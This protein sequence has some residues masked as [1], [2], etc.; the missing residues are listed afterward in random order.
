LQIPYRQ[1]AVYDCF[2]SSDNKIWWRNVVDLF[3]RR[4]AASET[5]LSTHF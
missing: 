2:D 4:H 3:V 1:A 5:R